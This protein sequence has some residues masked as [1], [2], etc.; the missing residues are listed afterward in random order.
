[1]SQLPLPLALADHATFDTFTPGSNAAALE[2]VRAV[3]RGATDTL[4]LWGP[5]GCGKTHLLQAAC[6]AA[7]AAGMRAMYV[8]LGSEQATEP[9]ILAGLESL[10]LLALDQVERVAAELAWQRALF[11]I[12]DE[13]LGR[14]GRLVLAAETAPGDSGFVLPDLASRAAGA[15]CYRLLPLGDDDRLLALIAHAGARGLGLDRAA[16]EYLLHRVDRDMTGLVRWLERL[17]HASLT[18]QRRL[19]IPF[20]RKLLSAS[21]G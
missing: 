1:L 13:F 11:M 7:A 15:V 2:H 17:D 6:R 4:W 14:R 12:L 18:E 16:A 9:E 21:G 10:E 20:I 3:A 19:T 8:A 5:A